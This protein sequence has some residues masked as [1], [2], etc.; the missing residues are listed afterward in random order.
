LYLKMVSI[1]GEPDISCN[2]TWTTNITLP[3]LDTDGDGISDYQESV[4]GTDPIPNGVIP[5]NPVLPVPTIQTV[6]EFATNGNS[7][8]WVLAKGLTG[9]V[10][11]GSQLLKVAASDPNYVSESNLMVPAEDYP[12]LRFRVK[13]DNAGS[14][15]IYWGR[16]G[17]TSFSGAR[18]L[19]LPIQD[20][21]SEFIDYYIDMSTSPEWK[22]NIFQLRLDPEIG[23]N[24]NMT[25]DR[26][27]FEKTR[28]ACTALITAPIVSFCPGGSVLLSANT[29]PGAS[30]KWMN[31]ATVV[32]SAA[33][34]TAR[35]VGSY[36][37]EVTNPSGCN[38]ISAAKIVSLNTVPVVSISN[39][40]KDTIVTSTSIMARVTLASTNLKS[41]SYFV[42]GTLVKTFTAAP[43]SQLISLPTLKAYNVK[44]VAINTFDC[45]SADSVKITRTQT[46]V[47]ENG[48]FGME[49]L[50][51][52][53]N[54]SSDGYFNLSQVCKWKVYSVVGNE[55]KSGHSN[56]VDLSENP[57]GVYLIKMKDK[58]LR[59]LKE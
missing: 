39:P 57:K 56:M 3:I 15:Q 46:T 5:V 2:V 8:G 49:E 32:G 26:I 20:N 7:E 28:P 13:S 59:V 17:A 35:T 52:Y 9:S 29:S 11:G 50:S 43:Y 27:S 4:N 58:I 30:F 44:A 47:L 36:T 37:V 25:I 54:P 16:D 31:G 10:T 23:V 18:V 53:P 24:G 34:Y 6:W 48:S 42:D 41:V 55:L 40:T 51:L 33:T 12:Y 22:E 1:A 38:A 19:V 14:I 45:V 21:P